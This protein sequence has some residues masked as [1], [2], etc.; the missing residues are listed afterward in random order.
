MSD[1]PPR[2][3]ARRNRERVLAAAR[4]VFA[5]SG[6]GVPLDVIAA[7]AGVGPG[8][9]YRH[10]PTKEALFEAVALARIQD[11][12]ADARECATAEDPRAAFDGFLARLA[13]QAVARSDLNDAIAGHG[14]A[15][16]AAAAVELQEAMGALITKAQ[17]AGSFRTDVNAAEAVVLLKGLL[18][19]VR[20]SGD[21][22]LAK[23]VLV[24]L[25]DGLT[26]QREPEI[27]LSTD[28]PADPGA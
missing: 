9:V 16:I 8:T 7:R 20:G 28:P 22:A 18:S 25:R 10:F 19:V 17:D 6:I 5:E 13:E 14:S 23:R 12:V 3:D 27:N 21:L 15:A 1:R 26:P 11:V 24:V 4:E 2:A